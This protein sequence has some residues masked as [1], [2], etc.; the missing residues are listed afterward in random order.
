ME[1]TGRDDGGSGD[2]PDAQGVVSG[3]IGTC[4]NLTFMLGTTSVTTSSTMIF[5]GGVCS[6]V[7]NGATV[8]ATGTRQTDGSIV[9]ATVGF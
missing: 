8:M 4:P 5:E 6:A 3:R 1:P 7:V 9:A 2:E